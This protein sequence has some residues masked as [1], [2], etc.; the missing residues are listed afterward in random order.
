ME[1]SKE[2]FNSAVRFAGVAEKLLEEGRIKPHPKEVRS[3][4]LEAVLGGIQDVREGVIR[5]RKL[6]YTM[7]S[8]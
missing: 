3:G 5:G 8:A 4:G 7:G 1:A 2:K 6:V